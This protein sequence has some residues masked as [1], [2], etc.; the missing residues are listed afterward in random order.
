MTCLPYAWGGCTGYPGG[1]SLHGRTI[2]HS[3]SAASLSR[4]RQAMFALPRMR[5][6]M[7]HCLSTERSKCYFIIYATLPI[8]YREFK[9]PITCKFAGANDAHDC[10]LVLAGRI[11]TTQQGGL[12]LTTLNLNNPE[13]LSSTSDYVAVL[14]AEGESTTHRRM[15]TIVSVDSTT[16]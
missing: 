9:Q 16:P 15:W 7:N 14:A 8:D 6:R 5:R 10:S 4:P 13:L 11:S 3:T 12:L 1:G 2:H